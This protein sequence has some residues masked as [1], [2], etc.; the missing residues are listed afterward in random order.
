MRAV[1]G[2]EVAIIQDKKVLGRTGALCNLTPFV[3][4]QT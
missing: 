2:Q 1:L 4:A 3:S